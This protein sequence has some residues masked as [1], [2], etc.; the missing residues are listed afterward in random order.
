MTAASCKPQVAHC[1]YAPP[2]MCDMQ[3]FHLL[4]EIL[5]IQKPGRTW[6]IRWLLIQAACL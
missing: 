1:I 3:R 6:V 2:A 5:L 4:A